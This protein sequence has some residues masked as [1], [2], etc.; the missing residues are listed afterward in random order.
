MKTDESFKDVKNL[1]DLEKIM[2]K[3]REQMEKVVALVLLASAIGLL[4]GEALRER[5]YGGNGGRE[6]FSCPF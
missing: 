2:N 5:V 4:V 6:Q 1:L 3:K